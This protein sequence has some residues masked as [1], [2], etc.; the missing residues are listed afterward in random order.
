[1]SELIILLVWILITMMFIK[2]KRVET[3]DDDN[4]LTPEKIAIDNP[5]EIIY[6]TPYTM[7]EE[8]KTDLDQILKVI[9]TDL[10]NLSEL[11]YYPGEVNHVILDK[12]DTGDRR[13][14][15]D[16]F[17]YDINNRYDIRTIFDIVSVNGTFTLNDMKM[18]T[19]NELDDPNKN[20]YE[21][22]L[23]SII[24]EQNKLSCPNEK[25]EGVSDST[26]EY[27]NEDNKNYLVSPGEVRNKWILDEKLSKK[28]DD[29][30]PENNQLCSW[31]EN[32]ILQN[33][34]KDTF[35]SL[36]TYNPTITGLP[37]HEKDQN[38]IFNLA[39][40]IISLP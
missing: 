38:S 13:F 15:I 31:D 17:I 18:V 9:L 35:K 7:T 29:M 2:R 8:I 25:Y 5:T 6:Y 12:N 36:P 37:H 34:K 26:L 28:C 4:I 23:K 3:F 1:M 21:G 11:K 16:M 14:I 24:H 19:K 20:P 32:S 27:K 40:G 30:K 39:R 33:Y 10:N 22:D